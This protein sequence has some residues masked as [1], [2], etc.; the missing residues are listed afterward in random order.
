MQAALRYK[1]VPFT[2][3]DLLPGDMNGDW[4]ERGFGDIKPKVVGTG[5]MNWR[6]QPPLKFALQGDPSGGEPG[7]G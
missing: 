6:T 7:L 3:H 5:E 2:T 1:R 4:E